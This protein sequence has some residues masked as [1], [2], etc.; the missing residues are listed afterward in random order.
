MLESSSPSRRTPR[1]LHPVLA[2]VATL[3]LLLSGTR[4]A[5]AQS[6]PHM[7]YNQVRQKQVH[8]AMDANEPILDMLGYYAVR[9]LEFDIHN[10]KAYNPDLTGDWW[11]YHS[12]DLVSE[13]YAH[14]A[15][16]LSDALKEV[17]TFHRLNPDHEVLTIYVDVHDDFDSNQS[18]D[19][20]DALIERFFVYN[21]TLANSDLFTPFHLY[22][23]GSSYFPIAGATTCPCS[24]L[25]QCVDGTFS[26]ATSPACQWP[27]LSQL[28]GKIIF[29]VTG[30]DDKADQY[31]GNGSL[32]SSRDA[33]ATYDHKYVNSH[34]YSSSNPYGYTKH[35]WEVFFNQGAG[36]TGNVYVGTNGLIT[37][38]TSW[39]NDCNKGMQEVVNMK[40]LVG[41]SY[42]ADS[43]GDWSTQV[44]RKVHII[45]TNE[46][47]DLE[48]PWSSTHN[49]HGFPFACAFT[50]GEGCGTE[51]ETHGSPMFNF[52][53]GTEDFANGDD[54]D[55]ITY[56]EKQDAT[57]KEWIIHV[58]TPSSH[59]NGWGKGCL[60]ARHHRGRGAAY[61]A[62]C[63]TA[64]DHRAQMQWRLDDNDDAL[65]TGYDDDLNTEDQI[66]DVIESVTTGTTEQVI[67]VQWE[68]TSFLK[69][70]SFSSSTVFRAF[71]SRD[72]L[73]WR[74][75]GHTITFPY[76]LSFKGIA[77]T[78]HGDDST[79][80][81]FQSFTVGG[82]FQ[83]AA[84]A[85]WDYWLIGSGGSVE[86]TCS[87]S[88]CS[89]PSSAGDARFLL[90]RNGWG[91]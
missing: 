18:A 87:S 75:I 7:R 59:V 6:Y 77:S 35:P 23:S 40:H 89:F 1:R 81:R 9:S 86:A 22:W 47:N 29:V 44:S 73:T 64:D 26:A 42:F 70:V 19:D 30:G 85:T 2:A 69:I 20:L 8:N 25:Q 15:E 14:S 91:G 84:D 68:S 28:R 3:A 48:D 10:G 65:A 72:R 11:L 45:G 83:N 71:V 51:A 60:M 4:L 82:T 12:G 34:A 5:A 39:A 21:D 33:F 52:T 32:W 74:Q 53:V 57:D 43:S 76:A 36:D 38:C 67:G 88:G 37:D 41:R 13:N 16:T 54:T 55:S 58:L 50:P 62:V 61:F 46:V 56:V 31:T 66:H 27:L 80:W 49:V 63:R 78:S 17:Q 24:N 90:F 79:L